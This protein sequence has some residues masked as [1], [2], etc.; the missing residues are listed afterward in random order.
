MPTDYTFLISLGWNDFFQNSFDETKESGL[1]PGRVISQEKIHFHVQVG[2][3]KVI[4]ASITGRLRH[5]AKDPT[6]LPAVGD[7]VVCNDA[8]EKQ[9][10]NIHRVLKRKSSIQRKKAG[11]QQ[12][13]QMIATNIDFMFIATSLN[14]DFNVRR[15]GRYLTLGWDSGATPVLLLT[16]ADLCSNPKDYV[17]QVKDEFKKVEIFVVS[18]QD[19]DSMEQLKPFFAPG[20]TSVLL[21]SSGVGKSTLSNYFLGTDAQKTQALDS[22]SKGKHT[23]TARNLLVTR[24]GGLVIDTPGMREISLLDQ[25]AG[26]QE[27]FSDIEEMMV[28]CKFTDCGHKTEPGCA[29]TGAIKDGT[30]RAERWHDYQKLLT[31]IGRYQK[32]KENKYRKNR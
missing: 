32:K 25:E 12:I 10:A 31:E 16:K 18:S 7:W 9:K 23:T 3:N 5:E 13:P 17:A 29:I 1:I 14:D 21:G 4:E 20:T 26:L 15:I 28:R 11:T 8:V 27:N 30:L 22:D 24:W 19:A 6:D 2:P